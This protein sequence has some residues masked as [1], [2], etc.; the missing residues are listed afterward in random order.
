MLQKRNTPE[1][2]RA[3]PAAFAW[4][5]PFLLDEELT[6]EE[7]MVRDAARDYARAASRPASSTRTATSAS[8]ARS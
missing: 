3:K 8:T 1:A 4:D 6:P 7:R 5:D 2:A